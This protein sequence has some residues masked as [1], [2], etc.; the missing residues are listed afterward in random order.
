MTNGEAETSLQKAQ[1]LMKIV[2]D[3]STTDLPN[4]LEFLASLHS[5]TGNAYL[6]MGEADLALEQ[7]TE[8]LKISEELYDNLDI[9]AKT[10]NLQ[11]KDTLEKTSLRTSWDL[12]TSDCNKY[13]HESGG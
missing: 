9:I 1:Q 3:L 13:I 5:S 11:I 10:R 6:E 2:Q 12:C 7:H 8:D 4:K